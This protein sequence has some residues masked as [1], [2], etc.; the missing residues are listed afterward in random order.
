[1]GVSILLIR[2]LSMV[3]PRTRTYVISG[4]QQPTP[5]LGLSQ[6][7]IVLHNKPGKMKDCAPALLPALIL[8]KCRHRRWHYPYRAQNR[9]QASAR[10]AKG[11]QAV[12]CVSQRV[13]LSARFRWH[14]PLY[15]SSVLTTVTM[16]HLE[17]ESARRYYKR[18]TSKLNVEIS[19]I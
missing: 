3:V 5:R 8:T 19:V 7:C 13:L 2:V 6:S 4:S 15:A 1:M 10:S 18:R 11:A 14:P 12:T 16:V 17:S 9:N